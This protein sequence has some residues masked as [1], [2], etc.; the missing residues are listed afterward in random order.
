MDVVHALL[1]GLWI[2]GLPLLFW[3]RWPGLTRAY[4]LY[5]I[6]FVVLSQVSHFAIG[7][8]FLTTISRHL[9][10]N[11]PADAPALM[12]SREWF[13]VR[14]S[15]W[16]FDLIPSHRTIIIV[17]EILIFITALGELLRMRRP[18]DARP[19][20]PERVARRTG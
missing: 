18:L 13:T 10:R 8:C 6:V 11:G 3:P 5:A 17:S 1:M 4:A 15:K 14:A 9:Q 16:L 2:L 20:S 7:E 12:A 19:R